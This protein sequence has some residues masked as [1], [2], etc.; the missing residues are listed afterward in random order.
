MTPKNAF[1]TA[2]ALA[3]ATNNESNKQ[4]VEFVGDLIARY[5]NEDRHG[6]DNVA[7]FLSELRAT[8]NPFTDKAKQAMIHFLPIN[9]DKGKL[10]WVE[11][12]GYRITNDKSRLHNKDVVEMLQQRYKDDWVAKKAGMTSLNKFKRPDV[13]TKELSEMTATELLEAREKSVKTFSKAAAKLAKLGL[14]RH[15]ILNLVSAALDQIHID[16]TLGL[17]LVAN[18]G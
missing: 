5:W 8:G 9:S 6:L 15:Q 4:L 11:G 1:Q 2:M 16:E 17:K 12:E 7:F 13:T 18:G 10:E 3:I 14:D